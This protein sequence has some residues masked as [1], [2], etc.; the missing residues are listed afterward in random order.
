MAIAEQ[1]KSAVGFESAGT[2][3]MTRAIG[4]KIRS[5]SSES[6]NFMRNGWRSERH[7]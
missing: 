6:L 4:T 2:K 3:R 7:A 5:Q 1:M